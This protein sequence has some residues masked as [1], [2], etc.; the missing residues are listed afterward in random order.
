MLYRHVCDL[1]ESEYY[2]HFHCR[3]NLS[4]D[5]FTNRQ[6]RYLLIDD[7][8]ELANFFDLLVDKVSGFSF[9]VNT[10][11]D[12]T[13]PSTWKIHPSNGNQEEFVIQ[14]KGSI[15]SFYQEWKR[16]NPERLKSFLQDWDDGNKLVNQKPKH[17]TWVFPLIQMGALNISMDHEATCEL[18]K[19]APLCSTV[20]LATGYFNLTSEYINTIIENSSASYEIL[21]AHPKVSL[22]Y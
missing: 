13:L 14:A 5:Y 11:N 7:S 15:M 1:S 2:I 18:F 9:V 21:M 19:R 22:H 17:D 12:L 8:S 4:N 20:K 10:K 6:D 3:A 16:S